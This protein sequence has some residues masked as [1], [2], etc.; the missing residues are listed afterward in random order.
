MPSPPSGWGGLDPSPPP[1]EADG[2]D[3]ARRFAR[4]FGTGDGEAVLAHLEAL[5]LGRC[6]G[7]DASDA[8]LRHL[9]GQRHLVHHIRQL[10]ARGR[11]GT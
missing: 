11:S 4:V 2:L 6:L 9:E 7:P 10:V 5:S 8:A 1:A 3:L